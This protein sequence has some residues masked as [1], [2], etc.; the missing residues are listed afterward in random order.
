MFPASPVT[1]M[2]RRRRR[3]V[4]RTPASRNH[5]VDRPRASSV[6]DPVRVVAGGRRGRARRRRDLTSPQNGARAY[7]DNSTEPAQW[8]RAVPRS[9]ETR[10]RTP[11]DASALPLFPF[12]F[13]SLTGGPHRSATAVASTARTRPVSD[14]V[15]TGPVKNESAGISGK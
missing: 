8:Y 9:R 5:P 11:A 10:V 3:K 15:A 12:F 14:S 13:S 4:P 7:S 6:V 2:Q 1:V